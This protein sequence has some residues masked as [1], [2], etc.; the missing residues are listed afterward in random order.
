MLAYSDNQPLCH[1]Q[2]LMPALLGLLKRAPDRRIIDIGCGNGSADK[3]LCEHGYSVTAIDNSESGI[4]N[5]THN[6]RQCHFEI[7]SCY[8]DLAARFGQFP[9]AVSIEVIE[10]LY[11][12]RLFAR[13]LFDV[14]EHG[15][16]AILT[17]P[18]NGYFKNVLVALAGKFDQHHSPL[19]DHGHIKFWSMKTLRQLLTEAGFSEVRFVCAGRVPI[20]AKSMI[21]VA[22]KA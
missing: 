16:T 10:H 17:T 13:R 3:V 7:A 21:A 15:G 8:D 20:L 11:D 2:Y 22:R 6:F 19:W 18:Y 12:P 9:I 5:A 14:T 4:A 1:H